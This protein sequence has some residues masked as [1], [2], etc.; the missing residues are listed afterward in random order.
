MQA[1][2][3]NTKDLKD[4]ELGAPWPVLN[5]MCINPKRPETWRVLFDQAQLDKPTEMF[6]EVDFKCGEMINVLGRPIFI[7][8]CDGYTKWYYKEIYGTDMKSI[9]VEERKPPKQIVKPPPY[10]GYGF[11]E[12]SL[13]NVAML[14]PKPPLLDVRKYLLLDWEKADPSKLIF[15]L[16]MVTDKKQ[17]SERNFVMSFS[18]SDDGIFVYEKNVPPGATPGT[19]RG[20]RAM[21]KMN[22]PITDQPVYVTAE[23]LYVGAVFEFSKRTFVIT[24]VDDCTAKFFERY[25]DKFPFASA[26]HV[27]DKFKRMMQTIS[28][29][30]R[31]D[32]KEKLENCDP[33]HTGFTD[34]TTFV[35]VLVQTGSAKLTPHEYLT[36]ARHYQYHT[37]ADKEKMKQL[38]IA[39]IQHGFRHESFDAG[40]NFRRACIR[41]DPDT[42][43]LLSR[44][45]FIRCMKAVRAPIS[46]EILDIYLDVVANADQMVEYETAVRDFDYVSRP[47]KALEVIPMK[48]TR[49]FDF[50]KYFGDFVPHVNYR[51]FLL[52]IKDHLC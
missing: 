19:Y 38:A 45:E 23:D 29:E 50:V 44:S 43:N 35:N 26:P 10:N 36:I 27:M 48:V 34:W 11:E 52:D 41:A 37:P 15:R 33:S 12:D 18:L 8:D 31:F 30:K 5:I 6:T 17:D 25:P 24:E 32:M 2:K 7:Y 42:T 51:N 14:V 22:D 9:E 3:S 39:L 40:G 13:R 28:A 49:N 47:A 21:K 1:A 16:K 20:N 46:Y 4:V